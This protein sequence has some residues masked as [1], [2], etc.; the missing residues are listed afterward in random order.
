MNIRKEAYLP[1]HKEIIMDTVILFDV[2][3]DSSGRQRHRRS[4][5]LRYGLY[6]R[7]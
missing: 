1:L 7:L 3:D 4:V 6:L 2:V 5:V